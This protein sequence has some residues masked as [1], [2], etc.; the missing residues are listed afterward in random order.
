MIVE[1]EAFIR[2]ELDQMLEKGG[3][4][5]I[6]INSFEA[7]TK[8]IFESPPDLLLLDLNLP[9]MSGSQICQ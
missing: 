4:D 3:Y 7:V 8:Q 5:R 9:G 1:D 2:E 6:A